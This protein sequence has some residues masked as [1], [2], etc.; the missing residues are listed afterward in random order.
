MTTDSLKQVDVEC[1]G[2]LALVTMNRPDK[3][4]ALTSPMAAELHLAL[5]AIA[6]DSNVRVLIL[7]GAR[8]VASVP[9]QTST[10]FWGRMQAPWMFSR[11]SASPNSAP[12]SGTCLSL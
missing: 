5:A 7:T 1:S 11:A 8:A 2:L 10:S 4:N 3:L 9:A 6:G 12:G